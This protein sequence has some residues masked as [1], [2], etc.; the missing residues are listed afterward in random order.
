MRNTLKTK[1]STCV[2]LAG[3][4]GM[5]LGCEGP[6]Q[7]QQT[8]DK[9]QALLEKMDRLEYAA[10]ALPENELVYTDGVEIDGVRLPGSNSFTAAYLDQAL[11]LLPEAQD[12]AQTGNT[13][14]KQSA[15]AI[16]ASILTDE[17]SYLTN[18]ADEAIQKG[19]SQIN[20]LR[21][22]ADMVKAIL[23]H[24]KAL[25]GDR[26]AVIDTLK[27]GKI[28]NG[29]S[30]QGI[31][32]LSEQVAAADKVATDARGK[33]AKAFEQIKQLRE[34]SL[35]FESLDL[36]LT[37][38]SDAAKGSARFAKLE[39]ATV[40]M[41]EGLL[42]E[43][44]AD[45]LTT[46]VAVLE[47]QAKLAERR[48]NLGQ[49]VVNEL[50]A[51]VANIKAERQTVADKLAQLDADRKAA[52]QTLTGAYN[53]I[54]ALMQVGGFDRMAKATDRF[55]KADE[56]LDKAK[57]GNSSAFRQMSLYALHA[58]SLQQQALAART[59]AAMLGTLTAA[60]P[61]VLGPA[62]H[63]TIT[64][65]ITQLEALDASVQAA[66]TEL[67]TK[68]ASTLSTISSQVDAESTEGQTAGK[69]IESFRSLITAAK[70]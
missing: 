20:L 6:S 17:G 38:E 8:A 24:N 53:E 26:A 18:E 67:D 48:K 3:V 57:S 30:V 64:Q 15:N 35:E 5:T 7:E 62:L 49:E 23:E 4:V 61:D 63:A 36:K 21:Q 47:G 19:T 32:Q 33:L 34:D 22:G 41:K 37:N 28:G 10:V 65:R 31:N 16:I 52:L 70:G 13:P 45:S 69:L 40:A 12:I 56:A 14:Q 9:L 25:A 42:A 39:K 55:T 50:E 54:D 2:L 1:F 44:K 29:D 60:G 27:T 11:V 51:K 58:R 46:D 43:A 59:Y 66:A 68:A